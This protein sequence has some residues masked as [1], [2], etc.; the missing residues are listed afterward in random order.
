MSI[1]SA[2]SVLSIASFGGVGTIFAVLGVWSFGGFNLVCAKDWPFGVGQLHR[3]L[4]RNHSK[5]A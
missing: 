2:G 1:G 3:R 4:R 5:H